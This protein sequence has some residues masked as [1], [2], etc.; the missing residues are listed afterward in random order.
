MAIEVPGVRIVIGP[1]RQLNPAPD[2]LQ[3]V[4]ELRQ[5]MGTWRPGLGVVVADRPIPGGVNGTD[6]V[7]HYGGHCVCETVTRE[8]AV[9]I[10]RLPELL[11]VAQHS[12]RGREVLTAI[13]AD[14]AQPT[15]IST[16]IRDPFEACQRIARVA[17]DLRAGGL[18][19]LA[20]RLNPVA[21]AALSWTRAEE[22]E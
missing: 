8:Y 18:Y 11:D 4:H 17:K 13:A 19:E 22:R 7:G 21:A 14:L 3:R 6:D 20:E 5:R 16:P 2:P 12:V 1:A 9:A 10:A 15:D